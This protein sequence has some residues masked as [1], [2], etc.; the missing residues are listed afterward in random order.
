MA[1]MVAAS[2][3]G[4]TETF[5]PKPSGAMKKAIAIVSNT[6][7]MKHIIV[8]RQID[9]LAATVERHDVS[10][11]VLEGRHNIDELGF[12]V[13]QVIFQMIEAD[14]VFISRDA[15]NLH[16]TGTGNVNHSDI[17]WILC[18]QRIAFR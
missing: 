15:M 9:Q 3:Y 12:M 16:A 6:V 11:W 8:L 14:A 18:D 4:S 5:L 10:G 17:G 2:A 1:V 13:D 7:T